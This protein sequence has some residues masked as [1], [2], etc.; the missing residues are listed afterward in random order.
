MKRALI[1]PLLVFALV[2]AA[3]GLGDVTNNLGDNSV[4]RP[5]DLPTNTPPPENARQDS[6]YD[7]FSVSSAD[8]S[9]PVTVTTQAQPGRSHTTVSVLDGKLV[10]DLQDAE[11]YTY[12]FYANPSADDVAVEAMFQSYGQIYNGIALVC[13]AKN[14]YT[15]WYEFR[16]SSTSQYAIYRYDASLREDEKNPYIQLKAGGLNIDVMR[17]T[18]ENTI[19]GVCQGSSLTLYVNDTEIATATDGQITEGGLVGVGVM[20]QSETP[21]NVRFDYFSYGEP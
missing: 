14:D 10:F 20:S 17:P 18:K 8:W 5:T 9:D 1:Y 4:V 16:V 19:R 13:R 6:Y 12:D 15:S 3:C 7:D 21:V 11:T 2:S